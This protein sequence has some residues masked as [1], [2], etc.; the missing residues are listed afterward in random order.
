MFSPF[1]IVRD[2]RSERERERVE[3]WRCGMIEVAK[4]RLVGIQLSPWAKSISVAG[5][6][7][8]GRRLHWNTEGD[9][10]RLYYYQP[11][12]LRYYLTV[13]Y[14][15]SNRDTSFETVCGALQVLD[16]VAR[17]KET[18][19]IVSVVT[20]DRISD[21]V[22]QRWG[23]ERHLPESRRRHFIKRFYGTYPQTP[24]PLALSAN[25]LHTAD[26]A[27]AT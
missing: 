18:D 14:I 25:P 15:V 11:L 7:W 20:N 6:W 8:N 16:E 22:V 23:W 5:V 24:L 12:G 4:G 9:R 21:R 27:L 26:S 10:C 13:S 17:I 1:P 19:A 3:R 2:L